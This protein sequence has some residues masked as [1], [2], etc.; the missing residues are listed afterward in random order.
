[1]SCLI[2]KYVILSPLQFFFEGVMW[3]SVMG[4]HAIQMEPHHLKKLRTLKDW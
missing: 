4:K 3:A 2:S 1:M